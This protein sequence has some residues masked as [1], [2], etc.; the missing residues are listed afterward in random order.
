V[1]VGERRKEIRS[2]VRSH[3]QPLLS[4][5]FS[6]TKHQKTKMFSKPGFS[7]PIAPYDYEA[8]DQRGFQG[9]LSSGISTEPFKA[10]CDFFIPG[11]GEYVEKHQHVQGWEDTSVV[12]FD[13]HFVLLLLS[14]LLYPPVIYGL[15]QYMETREAFDLRIP[16]ICWNVF[17]AVFSLIGSIYL[18]PIVWP[19]VAT[20][21]WWGS[22]CTRW[23]YAYSF[24]GF[25]VFLFDLSKVFEFVDTIFIVLRKKPLIFL[26]YYHHV[27]TMLFCWYCNQT[28]QRFGCYGYFFATLN[29]LVHAYMYT[30][31]AVTAMGFRP[32]TWIARIVTTMQL[33]QMFVGI[34]IVATLPTCPQVDKTAVWSGSLLYFSFFCLFAHFFYLRYFAPKPKKDVPLG[35][36]GKNTKKAQ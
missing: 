8:L 34:S 22:M 11:C 32:P 2:F 7:P 14:V 15:K 26:H 10:V 28:A 17:L 25:Y 3:S 16:L 30:Y 36:K 19:G 35:N 20:G 4:L 5:F 23:C 21:G 33:S 31:Y 24:G 29:L 12:F 9:N 27:T 18:I 6:S 1:V 13:N